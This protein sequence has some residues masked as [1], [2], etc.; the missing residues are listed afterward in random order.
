MFAAKGSA[1]LPGIPPKTHGD[2]LNL[3]PYVTVKDALA[4]LKNLQ[5]PN[6]AGASTSA[7]P[8]HHGVV[9]LEATGLA[10][11]LRAGSCQP[12]HYEEKRYIAVWEVVQLQSFPMDYIFCGELRE[13]Y[14]QVG[15]AVPV[16]LATAVAQSVCQVLVYEYE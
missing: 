14:Q 7:R 5:L 16:E 11:A 2:G 1:I 9:C 4:G 6:M 15:N 10:P 3:Q 12:F 8:G 13:Q